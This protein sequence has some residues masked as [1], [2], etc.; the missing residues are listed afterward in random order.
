MGLHS[1]QGKQCQMQEQLKPGRICLV[2]QTHTKQN[3]SAAQNRIRTR[4]FLIECQQPSS[5]LSAR[6][7]CNTGCGYL[8]ERTRNLKFEDFVRIL[9]LA[10][11]MTTPAI[12]FQLKCCGA[13]GSWDYTYSKYWHSMNPGVSDSLSKKTSK[14]FGFNNAQF[15]SLKV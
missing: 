10:A 15:S 6:P 12:L 11:P 9:K 4:N 5:A 8:A 13:D 7:Q 14:A 3:A 1:S 2:L